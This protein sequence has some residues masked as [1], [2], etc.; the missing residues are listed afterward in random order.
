M[1]KFFLLLFLVRLGAGEVHH[2]WAHHEH[3]RALACKAL[4]GERH[5]HDE[6][7]AAHDC[8]L[9]ALSVM[10]A[11]LPENVPALLAYPL[12]AWRALLFVE[13]PF[14][15]KH[16]RLLLALRGPPVVG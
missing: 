16:S 13:V 5:W 8:L 1:G 10:T 3:E 4:A 7:Y 2:L 12:A 14:V 6:R 11:S 15:S 9:C